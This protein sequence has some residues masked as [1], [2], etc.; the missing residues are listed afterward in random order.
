MLMEAVELEEVAVLLLVAEIREVVELK[1][2]V[3]KAAAAV[4][5]VTK[6]VAVIKK[7]VALVEAAGP[8]S[9]VGI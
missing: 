2:A 8:L 1:F 9:D 7:F 5:V 3:P 6:E 4:V